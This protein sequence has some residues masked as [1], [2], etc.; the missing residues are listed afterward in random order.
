MSFNCGIVGLPNVGK[1]TLFNALTQTQLAQ[2]ANY[3]FCTI[4]PNIGKVAVPDERLT[5]LATLAKSQKIIPAQLEFVDIAGLVKGASHGEGLGNQFLGNIRAVDAICHVI[6]CFDDDNITHVNDKVDP[7]HDADIVNMELLL[8]DIE[9]LHNRQ[10]NLQKKIRGGDKEASVI[11]ELIQTI[12]P[13]MEEGTPARLLTI[14]KNHDIHF[15]NLQLLTAK[16]VLYIAN[17]CEDEAVTGNE[18]A[19]KLHTYALEQKSEFTMISAFIEQELVALDNNEKQE[20]LHDLGLKETGLNKI[21]RYGY[22]LLNR[23]SFFTI[24]PKE[25]RSWSIPKGVTAQQSAGVIHTDMSK[26]FIAAEIIA[27]QDYL[28]LKTEQQCKDQGKLRIEGK[29]YIIQDGDIC[30]FRF[31]V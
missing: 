1:S 5:T 21:I 8:S 30:H 25:A 18:Y 9:S 16:P 4:E 12:L 26:G 13:F 11:Y 20:Y 3:P 2:S 10:T 23:I 7:I 6:R 14:D 24:G 27:C 19:K 29:D 31:N 28:T 22:H 15:K 17:V